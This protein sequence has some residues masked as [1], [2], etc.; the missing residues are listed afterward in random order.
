MS[1]SGA[2]SIS[3]SGSNVLVDAGRLLQELEVGASLVNVLFTVYDIDDS[4]TKKNQESLFERP[5][6]PKV[7]SSE[8]SKADGEGSI[9]DQAQKLYSA[10]DGIS[11]SLPSQT[12]LGFGIEDACADE[13]LCSLA[14]AVRE[15]ATADDYAAALA[16]EKGRDLP[17]IT[18]CQKVVQNEKFYGLF[19]EGL[20]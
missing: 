17:A 11:K 1:A 14:L 4:I 7:I 5:V 3:S 16:L 13:S 18:Q 6:S 9:Q 2:T 8:N 20:T 10:L 12:E 15:Q 19:G